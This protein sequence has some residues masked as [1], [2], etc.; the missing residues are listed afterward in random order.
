MQLQT[1]GLPE[2]A[3]APADVT[4]RSADLRTKGRLSD[5]HVRAL[6]RAH[7]PECCTNKAI[8][9]HVHDGNA[10][11]SDPTVATLQSCSNRFH[12]HPNAA[13]GWMLR[14][15]VPARGRQEHVPRTKRSASG[16]KSWLHSHGRRGRRGRCSDASF[17][18]P[19]G[20]PFKNEQPRLV[21]LVG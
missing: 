14:K 1:L 18:D 16:Y 21:T 5:A 9:A 11:A 3:P 19:I 13:G 20:F 15:T 2:S 10:D 8:G 7:L 4:S 12:L 17:V 6:T